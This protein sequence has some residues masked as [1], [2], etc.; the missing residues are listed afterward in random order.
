MESKGASGFDEQK[1]HLSRYR[2][3]FDTHIQHHKI[4]LRL[5]RSGRCPWV[6]GRVRLAT[7]QGK[8]PGEVKPFDEARE[9]CGAFQ[10]SKLNRWSGEGNVRYPVHLP[11]RL[12]KCTQCT[13]PLSTSYVSFL[14]WSISWVF[15]SPW[16]SVFSTESFGFVKGILGWAKA[17]LLGQVWWAFTSILL[18]SIRARLKLEITWNS[19][20]VLSC[21]GTRR[22][23]D[24][25]NESF[26]N[27]SCYTIALLNFAEGD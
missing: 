20:F 1:E 10:N 3:V 13:L 27:Q 14:C 9:R 18:C 22:F 12:N 7:D 16:S 4:F 11:V 26:Y 24:W 17:Y 25:V 15:T 6:V 5:S 19:H 8:P 23:R 2:R 21:C